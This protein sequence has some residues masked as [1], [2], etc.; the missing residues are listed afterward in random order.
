MSQH[1][2]PVPG[3]NTNETLSTTIASG[4]TA[5]SVGYRDRDVESA[6]RR[7][8]EKMALAARAGLHSPGGSGGEG[9]HGM[10]GAVG[11]GL[12]DRSMYGMGGGGATAATAMSDM[13]ACPYLDDEDPDSL[14]SAGHTSPPL[15]PNGGE[16]LAGSPMSFEGMLGAHGGLTSTLGRGAPSGSILTH[17]VLLEPAYGNQRQHQPGLRPGPYEG[18][19]SPGLRS[20]PYEGR[21][22]P[23]NE[24]PQPSSMGDTFITSEVQC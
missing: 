16:G 12:H 15:P 2:G 1:R 4:Q 18:R 20:G 22:S 24:T 14:S 9:L 5:N 10:G 7:I 11:A 8:T 19:V 23:R 13:A 6:E 3:D 17:P 21:V